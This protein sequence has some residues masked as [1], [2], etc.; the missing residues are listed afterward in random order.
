MGHL[1]ALNVIQEFITAVEKHCEK[2]EQ[3]QPVAWYDSQ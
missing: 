3:P 2:A 1:G